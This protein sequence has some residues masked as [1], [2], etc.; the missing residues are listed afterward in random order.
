[1]GALALNDRLV[2][3]V[4]R[5]L[6]FENLRL[7]QIETVVDRDLY[8]QDTVVGR[9]WC[10]RHESAEAISLTGVLREICREWAR[11]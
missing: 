2:L 3:I 10:H 4:D 9:Q 11:A 7:R 8:P 5:V 1:M 6:A